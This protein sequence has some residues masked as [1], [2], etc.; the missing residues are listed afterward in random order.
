VGC[1]ATELLLD[2]IEGKGAAA[3]TH[4]IAPHLRVRE[5]CGFGLRHGATGVSANPGLPALVSKARR[6][7]H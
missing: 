7:P 3:V 2:R 6:K 5:S 4:K 1:L